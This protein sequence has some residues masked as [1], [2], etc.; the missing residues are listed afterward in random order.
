M[1]DI[2]LLRSTVSGLTASYGPA[3]FAR[4]TA[5][6]ESAQELWDDLAQSGFVGVNVPVEFG[7]GGMGL[8]EL[9]IVAEETAAAGCPLMML[10][11]SPGLCVPLITTLGTEAQKQRWLPSLAEGAKMAFAV[12]EADAGSNTHNVKLRAERRGSTW[13]LSGSKTYI[14]GVDE[15]AN[16]MVVARTGTHERSGRARLSMFIV[17][18]GSPGIELQPI[19]TAVRAA[20]R[21]FSVFLDE[22]EVADDHLLGDEGDGLRQLFGGLNPERVMSGAV[23]IGLSRFC[24]TKAVDYARDRH[25]WDV[26]I[27]AHQAVA[28]PLAEAKIECDVAKIALYEAARAHD[29]G[30][31]VGELANMAKYVCAK[32]ARSAFDSAVQTHGG[33]GLAIEYGLA[34]LWGLVRLYEIAPVSREMILNHIAQHTL[35]LPKSY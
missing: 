14:S 28:H 32:S 8:T 1:T 10:V 18:S 23:C 15:A 16:L 21:Q 13:V 24:L 12:T 34:D 29:T 30:R 35:G 11:V 27:G 25:V 33:N 7:G 6:G 31:D 3:Y 22:V 4:K 20:E 9:A 5:A 26:P 2:D 17:P 19:P